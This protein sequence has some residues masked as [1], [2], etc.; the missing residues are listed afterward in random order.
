MFL[1]KDISLHDDVISL[2]VFESGLQAATK[3]AVLTKN[4]LNLI[5]FAD[6]RISSIYRPVQPKVMLKS[7]SSQ[8]GISML[9]LERYFSPK[10]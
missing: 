7:I 2:C 9:N 4:D 6:S 1:L 10:K 3:A 5:D 8:L